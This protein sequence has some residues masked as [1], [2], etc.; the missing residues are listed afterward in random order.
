MFPVQI[1]EPVAGL[2]GIGQ[3]FLGK[4]FLEISN[5]AVQRFCHAVKWQIYWS[6]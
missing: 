5:D 3:F 6:I 4:I 1:M 2:H